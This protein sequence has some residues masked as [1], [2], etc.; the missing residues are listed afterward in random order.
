MKRL[1]SVAGQF[2]PETGPAL[3]S[4]VA[5]LLLTK[6]KLKEKAIGVLVP[7]AGYMYSGHVAASVYSC[8][9]IPDTVIILGPNHTGTGETFSLFKEGSWHTP[10]GD[11][12]VDE[13][14]AGAILAKCKY[15]KEDTKAHLFEHSLEVQLPFLQYL[16][17]DVMI[18]PIVLSAYNMAAYQDL[19]AAIVSAI[20]QTHKSA[21][22]V[23]S[24]DMTHYEIREVAEKKDKV[25]IEAILK[26][27]E[28]QLMSSIEQLSISMCGYIPAVVMLIA[29]KALGAK[30]A[31]LVKY[32]TSG[33]A[34][35][36]YDAV[37]GYAGITIT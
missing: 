25:A 27:S 10:L 28:T 18:V 36:D 22:I 23:A 11:V 3:K 4:E 30:N 12:D 16:K 24:S 26:L 33:D 29:A 19:A 2:Y 17:K 37:V 13:N 5:G 8:I 14:I 6:D 7:H 32:Q 9:E 21:L 34:T 1:P 20:K 31:R 15:V 35:G